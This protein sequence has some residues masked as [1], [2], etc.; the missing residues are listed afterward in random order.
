MISGSVNNPFAD[1]DLSN[2]VVLNNGLVSADGISSN[3]SC[4]NNKSSIDASSGAKIKF[5]I[6]S[7]DESSNER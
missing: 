3:E 2:V 7:N 6:E 5:Q 1:E 4:Q